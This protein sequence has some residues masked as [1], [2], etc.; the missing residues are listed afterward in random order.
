MQKKSAKS[1]C[2]ENFALSLSRCYRKNDPFLGNSR[3]VGIDDN[4]S[5]RVDF[6]AVDSL[7]FRSLLRLWAERQAN[8]IRQYDSNDII[9]DITRL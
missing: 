1:S 6:C 3:Y 8:R 5:V 4:Q 7:F 2:Y 9:V